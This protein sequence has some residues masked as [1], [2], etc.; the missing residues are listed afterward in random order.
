MV[1]LRKRQWQD[2][3]SSP[4]HLESWVVRSATV[5]ALPWCTPAPPACSIA[6]RPSPPPAPHPCCLWGLCACRTP[7]LCP[8]PL[9]SLMEALHTPSQ[10]LMLQMLLLICQLLVPAQAPA[11]LGPNSGNCTNMWLVLPGAKPSSSS[12][13]VGCLLKLIFALWRTEL[14]QYYAVRVGLVLLGPAPTLL[15]A[16]QSCPSQTLV[17]AAV[18]C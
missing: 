10:E 16:A 1:V 4:Q 8:E 7:A 12:V 9:G 5:A 2:P 15:W 3:A 14:V 11:E 13:T 17:P 18:Q 6:A